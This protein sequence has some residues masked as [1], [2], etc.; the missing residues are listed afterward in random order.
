MFVGLHWTT[1][2]LIGCVLWSPGL[3]GGQWSPMNDTVVLWTTVEYSGRRQGRLAEYTWVHRSLLTFTGGVYYCPPAS[4]LITH[5][6]SSQCLSGR[7]LKTLEE[8]SLNGLVKLSAFTRN[9]PTSRGPGNNVFSWHTTASFWHPYDTLPFQQ[10]SA[11]TRRTTFEISS[12][13]DNDT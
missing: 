13:S 3:N 8:W 5:K 9:H 10:Q 12:R 7:T 11:G 4:S 2:E 6:E 1:V